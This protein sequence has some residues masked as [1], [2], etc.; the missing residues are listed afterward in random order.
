MLF[1]LLLLQLAASAAMT[2]V[3]W[4]VQIAI[5][6]LFARLEGKTFDDY[7]T[8]Y[9][10]RVTYVIAPLMFI[11]ATCCA[12]CLYLGD[13]QRMLPSTLLLATIWSSTALI[14]VP[15][16]AKL[17]PETVQALVRSN[18]IRTIAWTVRTV[19]LILMA[20]A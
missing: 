20:F 9:M 8:Q 17:T 14:Q 2:G 16:H 7:H 12:A 11:E 1:A 3:I 6:P 19:L 4:M 15:K 13:W 5:Y 10:T 18:W